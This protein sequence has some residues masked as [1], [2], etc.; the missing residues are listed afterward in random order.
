VCGNG[1]FSGPERTGYDNEKAYVLAL[2]NSAGYS[3]GSSQNPPDP[4]D[5]SLK[6]IHPST[7][8]Q[9]SGK[10]R[11]ALS[12][13]ATNGVMNLKNYLNTETDKETV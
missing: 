8:K 4:S 2:F 6:T 11:N 9:H 3:I 1:V 12:P 10:R 13:E 5:D 7:R